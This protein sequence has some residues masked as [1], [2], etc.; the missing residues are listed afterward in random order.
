MLFC[1]VFKMFSER[2]KSVRTGAHVT[3]TAIATILKISARQYRSYE[4][5][6][7]DPPLSKAIALADYFDV[8]LDYLVGR[9]DE[10]QRI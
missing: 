1:E 5:G 10:P 4:N 2:L 8:S 9:S 6:T 7:C 3:Q